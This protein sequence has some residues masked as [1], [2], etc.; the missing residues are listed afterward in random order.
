MKTSLKPTP[1]SGMMK[2]SNSDI[3]SRSALDRVRLVPAFLVGVGSVT[4]LLVGL[5][6]TSSTPVQADSRSNGISAR[7]ANPSPVSQ[8]PLPVVHVGEAL[9]VTVEQDF[10]SPVPSIQE[11]L[12]KIERRSASES[13]KDRVFAILDAYGEPTPDGKLHVSMHVSMERPGVAS[14]VHRETGKVL[15]S[16]RLVATNRVAVEEKNLTILMEDGNG[17]SLVLDGSRGASR[18]L[19][20]PFRGSEKRVRDL[21]PEGAEREFTYI[22]SACGCPVKAKV[23]RS[24]EQTR[25]SSELPVMFPDDPAAMLVIESLMGW[26]HAE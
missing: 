10:G 20:V 25:R 3:P 12:K 18:I 19:D 17:G 4:A 7:P 5:L 9:M 16:S 11:A 6:P 26:P 8:E 24:G 1:A 2:A 14:L 22:Y 21:W 13:G 23:R 15:W